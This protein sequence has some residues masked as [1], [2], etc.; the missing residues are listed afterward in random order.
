MLIEVCCEGAY[1]DSDVRILNIP[2]DVWEAHSA[3]VQR[4]VRDELSYCYQPS[5]MIAMLEHFLNDNGIEHRWENDD[6]RVVINICSVRPPMCRKIKY[7]GWKD[8]IIRFFSKPGEAARWGCEEEF[9]LFMQQKDDMDNL[10]S[11]AEALLM[12]A[13]T[14][15]DAGNIWKLGFE[16]QSLQLTSIFDGRLDDKYKTRQNKLK[17]L[18]KEV[19]SVLESFIASDYVEDVLDNIFDDIVEDIEECTTL[20]AYNTDD[21]RLALGRVLSKRED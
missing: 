18:R 19:R 6:A 9:K 4:Y 8:A 13:K 16:Q 14:I 12:K 15:D 20:D 21:I 7:T 17:M 1:A 11:Y 2:S 3:E 5:T 10:L